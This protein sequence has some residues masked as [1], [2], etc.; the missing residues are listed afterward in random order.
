[1]LVENQVKSYSIFLNPAVRAAGADVKHL[2]ASQQDLMLFLKPVFEA[3]ANDVATCISFWENRILPNHLFPSNTANPILSASH[4][5]TRPIAVKMLFHN[6]TS[7]L[8]GHL[9]YC[10]TQMMVFSALSHCFFGTFT[11]MMEGDYR[12]IKQ[13][14]LYSFPHIS[15]YQATPYQSRWPTAS[16]RHC[17]GSI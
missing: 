1:M 7:S 3:G 11:P 4:N 2:S 14:N 12:R 8:P 17:Q 15:T 13:R 10:S 6:L 16:T 5:M 9:F